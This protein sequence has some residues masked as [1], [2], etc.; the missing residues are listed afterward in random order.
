MIKDNDDTIEILFTE[1]RIA[2]GSHKGKITKTQET[3]A[4]LTFQSVKDYEVEIG[5]DIP[6]EIEMTGLKLVMVLT[7]IK[8]IA[9]LKRALD[10]AENILKEPQ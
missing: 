5:D 4:V 10:K 7:N 1:K 9:V 3:C 6:A 8:T 2:T